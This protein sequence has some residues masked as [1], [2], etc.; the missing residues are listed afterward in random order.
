LFSL[1]LPLSFKFKLLEMSLALDLE[2]LNE[3][4]KNTLNENLGIEIIDFGKD[5]IKGKMPVDK[6]TKQP[7]GVLHGGASVALA[8][9]LGSIASF[10]VIKD[11]G[12][13]I[14]GL[15]INANHLRAVR[16]GF[17]YGTATPIHIGRK[18]HI[19]EI[20]ILNEEDKLVC[21][22][23]FTSMIIDPLA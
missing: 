8:E 7:D 14:V 20:R 11:T 1:G 19:W 6:R 2:K 3:I 21:I 23:R 10:M 13:Q 15:E 9:T 22:S 18:T 5:F 12:K 16:S 17:V 4:G